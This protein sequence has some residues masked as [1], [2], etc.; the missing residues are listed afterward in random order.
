DVVLPGQVRDDGLPVFRA[1]TEQ[2]VVHRALGP[3]IGNRARLVDVEVGGR[4]VH[5]VTKGAAPLARGIG[6]DGGGGLLRLRPPAQDGGAERRGSA[7]QACGPEE[8]ATA[9][10]FPAVAGLSRAWHAL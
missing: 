7:G 9:D 10:W 2:G 8:Y 5:G 6:P 4:I 3:D 1:A